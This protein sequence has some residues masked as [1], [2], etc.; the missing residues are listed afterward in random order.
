[1]W[2]EKDGGEKGDKISVLDNWINS[3]FTGIGKVESKAGLGAQCTVKDLEI[4]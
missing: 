1:M 2:G 3:G 4:K